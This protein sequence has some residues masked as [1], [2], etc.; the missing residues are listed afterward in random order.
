MCN[1][2]THHCGYSTAAPWAIRGLCVCADEAHRCL[3][4][5]AWRVTGSLK[6]QQLILGCNLP[7]LLSAQVKRIGAYKSAGDQLLR[8]SMAEEQREQLSEI[9]VR[10]FV[11]VSTMVASKLYKTHRDLSLTCITYPNPALP[12]ALSRA[13]HRRTSWRSSSARSLS[14]AARP[15]RW[16]NGRT[17]S[18]A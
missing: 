6:H 11:R 10:G 16:V 13:P 4:V 12:R 15:A 17:S 2:P 1:T 3:P 18:G 5:C 7:G 8:T 14:R 9:Q